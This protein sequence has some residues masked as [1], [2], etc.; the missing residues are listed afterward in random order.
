VKNITT[1]LLLLLFPF[2]LYGQNDCT[3]AIVVC[4]NNNYNSLNATGMGIQELNIN[5]A[6]SG[7]ENNSLWLKVPIK[8]GGSL[9]FIITPDQA[10]DLEVDFDFWVFGPTADCSNLGTAIRCSTTNPIAAGLTY[11]TTGVRQST[12]GN[13]EGPGEDGDG[14][15]SIINANDNDVYYLVIDRPIGTS[16]FSLTWTGT[17]KFYDVPVSYSTDVVLPDIAQCDADG[18]DDN[19]TAFDLT[20][21]ENVLSG[22]QTDIAFTYHLTVNDMITGENAIAT[23]QAYNNTSNPQPIYLRMTNTVTG[24]FTEER[25]RIQLVDAVFTGT[26]VNLTLCDE[27]N[28]GL[29]LF[30]LWEN[31]T[32]L[33]QGDANVNVRYYTTQDD[34]NLEANALGRFYQ[35][36]QPFTPET[37]YA[38]LENFTGCFGYSVLPFTLTVPPI[39]DF[40]YTLDVTDLTGTNN[41]TVSI[42][43]DSGNNAFEFSTDG[44]TFIDIAT[45]YQLAPGMHTFYIRDKNL[46]NTIDIDVP[47]LSYPRFFTPNGD[48]YNEIWS[49]DFIRYYPDAYIT[50]FDRYGNLIYGFFGR[51][52]GWDGTY[53]GTPIPANDYW[54]TIAFASGR[55]VKGHFSLI[56]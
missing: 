50:I 8:Q 28:S 17:A 48:S 51:E 12:A 29:R 31:N 36:S 18:T 30:D 39:A 47:I 33:S 35:N 19:T 26:P 11:N 46:C 40:S 25:I 16:N 15:V 3:D 20:V 37:I 43:M 5:N 55:E 7:V 1:A 27:D 38:R 53:N 41:N 23:P 14:Y 52:M 2:I 21:H 4:G 49:I 9:G 24:C 45:F 56:R 6:C 32:P 34:A 13:S 22:P 42:N 44:I 10:T 54:F